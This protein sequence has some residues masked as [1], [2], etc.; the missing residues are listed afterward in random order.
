MPIVTDQYI[1]FGIPKKLKK[2]K[3]VGFHVW[4]E[5]KQLFLK[6]HK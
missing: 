5:L 4:L 3:L 1:L 6:K 2:K